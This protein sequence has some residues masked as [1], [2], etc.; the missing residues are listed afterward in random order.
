MLVSRIDA[1]RHV[2]LGLKGADPRAEA[3]VALL[4]DRTAHEIRSNT[5]FDRAIN[6]FGD[7]ACADNALG[8]ACT[9]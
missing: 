6:R 2:G 3:R 8:A 1:G 9:D 5:L 7:F 4:C